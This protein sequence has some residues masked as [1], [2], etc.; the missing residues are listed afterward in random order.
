[1]K[2]HETELKWIKLLPTPFPLG[3]NDN[4]HHEGNISK[5][6]DFDV[7]YLLEIRKRKTRSH[8]IGKKGNDKRKMH[9]VKRSNTS[10]KDLS[11]IL[12]DHGR[13]SMLSFL[14]SL[15]TS[16][17]RVL[18]TEANKFYDRNHQWYDA[19]LLIRCYDQHALRPF[20]DLKQ[21][22]NGIS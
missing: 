2:R 20:I 8:C 21:I 6:P 16:V 3:C 7:F 22:T 14:S 18:D 10:L 4:I 11:K 12:E 13:H 5:M 9:A 15:P 17:L 19:A 1:M